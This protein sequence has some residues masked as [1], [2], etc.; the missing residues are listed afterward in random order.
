MTLAELDI[1]FAP[2][3][4]AIPNRF[5]G[6]MRKIVDLASPT[7]ERALKLDFLNWVYDSVTS[8]S[9]ER[10]FSDRCL[11]VLGINYKFSE[12]LL[13]RI[14]QTGP[15]VVVANHPFGAIDG[16]IL[17]SLLRRVRSDVKLL[18]T[19]MLSRMPAYAPDF[20]FVD[21]FST[22]EAAAKNVGSMKAAMR[23][24]RDGGVLG[25]FPSGEVS[26]LTL[27]TLQVSDPEWIPGIGR[28]IQKT[29]AAVLPIFFDGRNSDLFQFLGLIHPR[30]RTAWL[31]REVERAR[32]TTVALRIG[33]LIPA[34]KIESFDDAKE[35]VSYLR[36]RTYILRAQ[37]PAQASR[38]P[39]S[40]NESPDLPIVAAQS[41][42]ALASEIDALPAE[43][44][45]LTSGEM[46][47][48]FGRTSQLPLVVKELGR[49]REI[50]F[51][52]VG[53]G[54]GRSIDLDQFDDYYIHLFAWNRAK[55]ELIGAYRL[56]P[57]DEILPRFGKEG[58]YTTTLFKYH[59]HLLQQLTPALELGRS[60][61]RP[62]YQKN[63]AP[64]MLLWKGIGQFV[65]RYPRY[66]ML[67][68][69]VS[70]S[71]EYKSLSKQLL[72]AFLQMNRYVPNLAKLVKPRNPPR[73]AKFRDLEHTL[74]SRVVRDMDEVNDL[75]AEIE[76]D[77]LSMPILLRQYLKLNAKLLGFNVDPDFGD[78]LDGLM[79]CDLTKV[80]RQ[81]MIRYMGRENAATF[82][83][84]HGM[85][86]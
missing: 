38:L 1:R 76:S 43:Q 22:K 40:R 39:A 68:G 58:L 35:M 33:S 29:G 44:T 86:L 45:L 14:P 48:I 83:A 2:K 18:G 13:T 62:E 5:G 27:K 79:L 72:M 16:I 19:T 34:G 41:S 55:K 3:P 8:R 77:R 23:W 63:Y 47:A 10:H 80:E 71:A 52:K 9:A 37:G 42:D 59:E 12:E 74:P 57:T 69:P 28:L 66:K 51:R 11:D 50:T 25:V 78:V 31:A 36:M 81:M 26:H 17:N 60:F 7:L 54:T 75:V 82:L 32:H 85:K 21:N 73:G 56:G 30:L 67:F 64:L 61:V 4:F 24:V 70:I 46:C 65:V 15:L 53:E 6:R 20:F 84:H 49:L